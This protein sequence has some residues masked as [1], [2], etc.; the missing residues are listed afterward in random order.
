VR[1]HRC[2]RDVFPDSTITANRVD[3]YPV[4]VNVSA[5]VGS[6]NVTIWEGRQQSLFRKNKS[7]RTTSIKEIK[8][9]LMELQEDLK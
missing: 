8:E 2:V 9:R 1:L 3:K 4:W 6:S 5:S 7:S